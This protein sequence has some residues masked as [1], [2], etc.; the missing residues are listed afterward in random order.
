MTANEIEA[1]IA[2]IQSCWAI[3]LGATS[4]DEVRTSIIM[5]LNRDGSLTSLPEI[6]SRPAGRYANIA[7]ES[8]VT[9]IVK[10]A[11]Y[12]LPPEKYAGDNGWN[13]LAIDF[14]PTSMF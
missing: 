14:Y 7:P 10:C 6:V 13:E 1:L 9:A 3:P 8:V 5:R 11:P 4:A 12:S 2:R